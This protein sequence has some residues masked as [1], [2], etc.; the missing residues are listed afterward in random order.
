MRKFKSF[1]QEAQRYEQYEL[2]EKRR[3]EQLEHLAM[4]R[5]YYSNSAKRKIYENVII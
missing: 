2:A 4:L 3:R 5:N 1:E